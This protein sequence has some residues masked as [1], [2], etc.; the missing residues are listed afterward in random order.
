LQ[1]LAT[2]VEVLDV[3][4]HQNIAKLYEFDPRANLEISEG[5]EVQVFVII[6]EF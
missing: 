6:M 2:E 3:L 4:N 5:N 1:Q